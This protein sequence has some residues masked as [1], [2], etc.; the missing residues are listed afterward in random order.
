MSDRK[1]YDCKTCPY[2]RYREG[3]IIFCDVCMR[4]ILDEK[5]NGKPSER[6]DADHGFGKSDDGHI[7]N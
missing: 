6:S 7:C 4:R 3:N 2:P 1:M 5:K